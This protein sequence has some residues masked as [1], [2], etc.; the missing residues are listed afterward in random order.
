[1]VCTLPYRVWKVLLVIRHIQLLIVVHLQLT[2]ESSQQMSAVLLA[3]MV[4]SATTLCVPLFTNS[5]LLMCITLI[6]AHLCLE[7]LGG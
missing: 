4:V 5:D 7:L 2:W 1:M 6:E 3:A